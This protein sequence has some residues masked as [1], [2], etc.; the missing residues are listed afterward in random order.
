MVQIISYYDI[1]MPFMGLQ[2]VDS[3]PANFTTYDVMILSSFTVIAVAHFY[4][5]FFLGMLTNR[6]AVSHKV[7]KVI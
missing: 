3:D 1:Y 2:I 6:K 5:R 7:Y 4:D